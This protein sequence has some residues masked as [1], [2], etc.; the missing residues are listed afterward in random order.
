MTTRKAMNEAMKLFEKREQN[1]PIRTLALMEGS[2]RKDEN[3]K[4]N[5]SQ[6]II[7][8]QYANTQCEYDEFY[9]DVREYDGKVFAERANW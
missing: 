9:I 7:C 1:R 2:C 4:E 5:W 3:G 6:L 8:I